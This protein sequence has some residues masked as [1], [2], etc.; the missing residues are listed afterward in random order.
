MVDSPR[1]MHFSD[2]HLGNRE[3]MMDLREDDFYE[4][5]NEAVDI[6]LEE[7]VDFIIHSGDLFDTWG[8]SN[9]ALSELKDSM[10]RLKE[11]GIM[12]YMVMGDHDRPRRTDYPAASIFDFLGLTLMGADDLNTVYIEDSDTFIAGISNMKGSRRDSLPQMYARADLM[13]KAYRNSILISHQGVSGYTHPEDVQIQEIDLPG[14]F[15]YLAFGHVHV[16]S[17]RA[18]PRPF[19]YAGSTEINSASEIEPFLRDGKGVN[20]VDIDNGEV[21]FSRRRL[22]RPRIQ[23]KIVTTKENFSDDVEGVLQKYENTVPG[24]K[25]LIISE[26]HGSSDFSYFREKMATYSDRAIFRRPLLVK[27]SAPA[28]KVGEH[29]DRGS[30]F[31]EYFRGDKKMTDLALAAYNTA[32]SESQESAKER[33]LA[34]ILEGEKKSADK[35]P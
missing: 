31:M 14:S 30:L 15:A 4:A 32:T 8:P 33:I 10:L 5:Y 1:F 11:K 13:A 18:R 35:E 23:I 17:Y 19:S 28:V 3:Y 25:P 22:K 24:K 20:I 6:A 34:L 7:R 26:V 27:E 21:S 2:T 12:T 9:R 29:F 16:S